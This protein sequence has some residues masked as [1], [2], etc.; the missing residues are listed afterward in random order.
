MSEQIENQSEMT[1]LGGRYIQKEPWGNVLIMD[2]ASS[3]MPQDTGSFLVAGSHCSKLAAR[4][5]VPILPSAVILNDAG[6]GKQDWGVSGLTG[7]NM[8]N[9]PAAAVDCMSGKIGDGVDMYSSGI[10]SRQNSLA[11]AAGVIKGMSVRDAIARLT[12]DHNRKSLTPNVILAAEKEG[13]KIYLANT[14]SYLGAMHEGSVI[15]VG[16]HGSHIV[17]EHLISLRAKAAFMND[18][19]GGKEGCGTSGLR[20]L[21]D[22]GILAAAFSC[23]SARIGDAQDAWDNGKICAINSQAS[24]AGIEMGMMVQEAA[25]IACA[26]IANC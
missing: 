20:L 11:K 17:A 16:S 13:R 23:Q 22:K 12:H 18:A 26:Q 2:S 19:G 3:V 1:G 14:A 9:I 25:Q 8:M 5:I 10:I 6:I 24:E 15:I 21:T 4:V 7:F